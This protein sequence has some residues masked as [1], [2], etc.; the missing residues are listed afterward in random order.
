M[1]VEELRH[2]Q[3]LGLPLLLSVMSFTSSYPWVGAI[4]TQVV[5][6]CTERLEEDVFQCQNC[7]WMH[8]LCGL[9]RV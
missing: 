2:V 8:V 4:V 1:S 6:Q 5:E 3:R 9:E 7:A